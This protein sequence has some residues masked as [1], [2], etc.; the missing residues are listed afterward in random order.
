MRLIWIRLRR[1]GHRKVGASVIGVVETHRRQSTRRQRGDL[2]GIFDRIGIGVQ[3]P[4]RISCPPGVNA[5][6]SSATCPWLSCGVTSK[7]VRVKCP[8]ARG[9]PHSRRVGDAHT[10]HGNVGTVV[11]QPVSIHIDD[12]PPSAAWTGTLD[13]IPRRTLRVY[14]RPALPSPGAR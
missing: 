4:N 1:Q 13:P 10:L 3:H 5:A 7:Q 2:D 8:P 14:R 6:S 12:H 9:P 11:D